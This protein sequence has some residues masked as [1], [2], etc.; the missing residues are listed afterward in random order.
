[1]HFDQTF[2]VGLSFITFVLLV[3]KPLSRFLTN[4]L[5]TR[6]ERIQKELDEAQRLKEEAQSLLSSYQQKQTETL[7]EAE[8]IIRHAEEEA[9]RIIT[10]AEETLEDSL[11]KRIELSMQKIASYESSVLRDVHNRIIDTTVN[12]VSQI[13][14]ENL[15]KEISESLVEDAVAGISKKLH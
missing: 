12:T 14:S 7:A 15:D 6:A 10:Q 11:N 3:W 5:D 13:L 2:W 1:M 8:E 4:A 9:K